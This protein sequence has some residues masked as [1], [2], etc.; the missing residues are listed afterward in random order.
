MGELHLDVLVTRIL[1]EYKVGAKVGN[2]QVTY[3]ESV[4]KAVERKETFSKVLA[5]KEN[6]AGV[7]L[8]VEPLPRGSGNRYTN[9]VKKTA[10]PEEIFDAIERGVTN[11]FP[12]AS[13]SATQA[14]T[15]ASPRL[16]RLSV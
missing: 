2:P 4:S 7:T 6:A 5:G 9:A 11:A 16:P 1:K 13:C 3:R 14:S 15:W 12:S 10:A 8:R